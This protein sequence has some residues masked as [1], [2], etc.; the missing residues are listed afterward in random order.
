M[1]F[2][3]RAVIFRT[4]L[5]NLI[6]D[7]YCHFFPPWKHFPRAFPPFPVAPTGQGPMG[8]P[9]LSNWWPLPGS[10]PWP[11]MVG[12]SISRLIQSPTYFLTQSS[13]CQRTNR[14]IEK[15][16]MDGELPLATFPITKY[17]EGE[18]QRGCRDHPIPARWSD[19]QTFPN[20]KQML[21]V[22]IHT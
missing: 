15:M 10:G 21:W 6:S 12:M 5:S 20:V 14:F 9:R 22:W 7:S 16:E 1:I 17:Q 3:E 4:R 18:T 2:G 8:S 11:R 13:W 19:L